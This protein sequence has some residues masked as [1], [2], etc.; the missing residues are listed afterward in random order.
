MNL[1]IRPTKLPP[2]QAGKAPRVNLMPASEVARRE[3]RVLLRNW[4]LGLFATLAGLGLG[5][6]A[7]LGVR[8]GAELRLAEENQRT[9]Q[10]T[11]ALAGYADVT[12]SLADRSA[13]GDF[14]GSA[15]ANDLPW[16]ELYGDISGALP[17]GVTV[18]GFDLHPGAAPMADA[19]PAT[20]AG[21]T[22]T[23]TCRS[24]D[25]GDQRRMVTAL[26]KIPGA[27]AVDAGKLDYLE[28]DATYEYV[29]TFVADQT[30]YTGR[31]APEGGVK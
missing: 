4:M 25:P 23:I 18:R 21:L 28:T 7:M 2:A 20:A 26:R 9:E 30:R 3:R 6:G 31:F 10:L 5:V 29:I 16:T 8:M 11:I 15:A 24:T 17:G 14:R 12:K 1:N 22:G 19:D 13:L 27:L